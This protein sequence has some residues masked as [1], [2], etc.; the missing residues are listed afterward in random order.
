MRPGDA[1]SERQADAVA[2]IAWGPIGPIETLENMRQVG[3]ADADSE[4]LDRNRDLRIAAIDSDYH[5][6]TGV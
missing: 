3:C 5:I 6:P 2:P 4:V 1:F